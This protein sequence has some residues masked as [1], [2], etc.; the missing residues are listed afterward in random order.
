MA[1]DDLN[2]VWTE[3]AKQALEAYVNSGE[4]VARILLELHERSTSWA[5]DTVL[6]PFFDAQRTAGKRILDNSLEITRKLYNIPDHSDSNS[7]AR[8]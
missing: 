5:R 2:N 3:K 1:V 6:G 7:S 4:R 8:V